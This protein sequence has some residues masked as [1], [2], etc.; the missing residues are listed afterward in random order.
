MGNS[1]KG[2]FR[3]R[4]S[5]EGEFARGESSGGASYGNFQREMFGWECSLRPIF[6]ERFLQ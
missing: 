3:G 6:G 4:E 1:L 5:S 2:S